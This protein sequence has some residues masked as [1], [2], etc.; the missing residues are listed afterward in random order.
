MPLKMSEL[1]SLTLMENL[2][3]KPIDIELL[4]FE[5]KEMYKE[6]K[7]LFITMKLKGHILLCCQN[8]KLLEKGKPMS[9]LLSQNDGKAR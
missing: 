4:F 9:E 5:W 3:L 8:T 6:R 1:M 2:A 7:V